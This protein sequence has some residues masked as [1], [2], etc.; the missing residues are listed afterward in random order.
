MPFRTYS[1]VATTSANCAYG[2]Q[3]DRVWV[4]VDSK[5]QSNVVIWT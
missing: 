5:Y 1:T 4:V 2:G 3:G